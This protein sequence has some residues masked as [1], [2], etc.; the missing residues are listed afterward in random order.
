[1]KYILFLQT[2]DHFVFIDEIKVMLKNIHIFKHWTKFNKS[3]PKI[4]VY[5]LAKDLMKGRA[6]S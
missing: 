6:I 5:A 3:F 4:P 2:K 1:M